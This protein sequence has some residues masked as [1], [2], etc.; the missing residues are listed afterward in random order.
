MNNPKL[1]LT[2]LAICSALSNSVLAQESQEETAQTN[3]EKPSIALEVIQVTAQRR[4]ENIQDVPISVQAMSS[5]QLERVSIDKIDDL[6]LYIPNLSMTETG[7]STQTFI[8]GVGSGNNQGFE[9]SVV[10]FIDGVSYARQQLTRAPFFDMERAEVLRGPQ[11]ILFGKNAIGGALNFTTAAVE[12]DNTGKL[13]LQVGEHGIQEVQGVANLALVEGKLYGRLSIRNYQ[14]DGYIENTTLDRDEPNR[15]D[16]TVRA[17]LKYLVNEDWTINFK[18][19]RN[20]FETNGRHIEILQDEGSPGNPFGA[21][22]G[23]GFG[24][25]EA[26]RETNLDYSR[27]ANGDSST[28]EVNN[29]VVEVTGMV[30]DLEFESRTATLDYEF[31]DICDCDYIGANIF[32]VPMEEKYD[33]FSQEFR[34]ASDPNQKVAWQ[35]GLFYQTS[36]LDFYDAIRVPVGQVGQP[37]LSVLPT[38]V[39]AVTGS[40]A[41]GAALSGISGARDFTQDTDSFS[42]FGQLVYEVTDK[43]N[44]SVGARWSKE[45]KDGSRQ[46][47]VYTIDTR[48][49]A[50]NPLS[51][52]VLLGLFGI[53]TEQSTGHNLSG[54]RSETAF[55]P[56]INFQYKASKDVMYYAGWSKGSKSG[57]YDARANVV[58]SFE[59]DAEEASA[60][61]VGYKSTFWDGRARFNA[62]IYYT[63]FDDLQV[64]QFDGTLGFVV[65]NATSK[66]QG[67][68]IDGSF[69]VTEDFTL[70]YS[71][72]YLDQEFTDYKDGNCFYRQQFDANADLAARYN[73]A[74]GLCD[75]TGLSGQYTPTIT[76]N[77]N[78]DYYITLS[79]SM[80]LRINVNYNY[81]GG[82]NV[83]QNL[84]PNFDE[85][86][87]GRLDA[88]IALQFDTWSVEILGRNITDEDYIMYAGNSP[89]SGTFGADTIYGFI[90]PPSTWSLR[91]KFEF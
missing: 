71:A 58:S 2:A 42:V 90:A 19:E 26:I 44:M 57:G 80:D 56:S 49:V 70:S 31:N 52:L 45:D 43:L 87:I 77:L 30:G 12:E 89:L 62:A 16:Q 50:P 75:Y 6:Q 1:T 29:F 64:S 23:A 69:A 79:D 86:A 10:Q 55:D 17:K 14:E 40:A 83:H 65:G 25:T 4:V 9:Q 51:A 84:D 32:T 72:A 37:N 13:F 27:Q 48:D 36:E 91:A 41:Q 39:T 15:D 68:E 63:D 88:N 61:E 18:Y 76:A 46:L 74:T 47:N 34:V 78:A 82:Q 73:P 38:A 5:E 21:T 28:N 81:T 11:S 3:Q 54:S 85:D 22:L 20:D 59:F 8:R 35:A 53:E 60:F 24:L 67:I 33:Q 7:L 66:M